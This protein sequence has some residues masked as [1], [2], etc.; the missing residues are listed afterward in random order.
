MGKPNSRWTDKRALEQ[1]EAI[2]RR[3]IKK[4]LGLGKNSFGTKGKEYR[5]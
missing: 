3:L 2:K 4:Q 5:T 1:R